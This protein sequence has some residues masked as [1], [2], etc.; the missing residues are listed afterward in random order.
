MNHN[1]GFN[2]LNQKSIVSKI[3]FNNN[4]IKIKTVPALNKKYLYYLIF[5]K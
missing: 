1:Q 2:F 5:Q 3:F 4:K